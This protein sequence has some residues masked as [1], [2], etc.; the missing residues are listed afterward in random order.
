MRNPA[1]IDNSVG[2][3]HRAEASLNLHPYF[4]KAV[5]QVTLEY[6][7]YSWQLN[8][9]LIIGSSQLYAGISIL[10]TCISMD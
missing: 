1:H 4:W 9:Y 5:G 6:C 3:V 10:H 7:A 2:G 8:I